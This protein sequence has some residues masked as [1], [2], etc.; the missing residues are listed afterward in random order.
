MKTLMTVASDQFKESLV[1]Q[2]RDLIHEAVLESES[3]HRT[4]LSLGKL[5]AKFQ[6]IM[7]AAQY[8]GVPEETINRLIDEAVHATPAK[9]A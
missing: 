3:D 9:A 1:C 2:Y 7:K 4:R 8:D 6:L 5:N